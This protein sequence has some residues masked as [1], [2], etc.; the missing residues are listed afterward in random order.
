VG[1]VQKEGDDK[2]MNTVGFVL[3]YHAQ[4][5]KQ[6]QDAATAA[7][8]TALPGETLIES[9]GKWWILDPKLLKSKY[10]AR[11][12]VTY[13]W[14]KTSVDDPVQTPQ[15]PHDDRHSDYAQPARVVHRYARRPSTGEQIDLCDYY[16]EKWPDLGRFIDP[17]R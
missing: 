9:V 8:L 13:G 1:L 16:A 2:L 11:G 6:L 14:F 12:A 5:E 15:A 3:K 7:G 17:F 10:G 4:L